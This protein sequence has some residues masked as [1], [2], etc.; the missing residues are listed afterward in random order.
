MSTC[1]QCGRT[2]YHLKWCKHWGESVAE[3]DT[4]EGL[5]AEIERLK[6][7]FRSM[8]WHLVEGTVNKSIFLDIVE[9]A[10]NEQRGSIDQVN[11]NMLDGS[12]PA[13]K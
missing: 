1:E 4:I 10:L 8:H 5:R 13:L 3:I 9:K 2:G 12:D 6:D 11:M 7:G